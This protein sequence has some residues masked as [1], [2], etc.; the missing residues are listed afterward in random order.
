MDPDLIAAIRALVAM[1]SN[2]RRDM[3]ADH[4]S[5][6][7]PADATAAPRGGKPAPL[8]VDQSPFSTA[9]EESYLRGATNGRFGSADAEK[10]LKTINSGYTTANVLRSMAS[11]P[12]MNYG[13][14]LLGKVPAALGGG[15]GAE[16]DMRL[17]GQLFN[18]KHPVAGAV[19]P[20]AGLAATT[21]ATPEVEGAEA[22]GTG[23]KMLKGAVTGATVGAASSAGASEGPLRDRLR[24]AMYGGAGGAVFGALIPGIA[25]AAGDVSPTAQAMKKIQGAVDESGGPGEVQLQL[26]QHKAAGRG[27]IVTLADLTDPL[28]NTADVAATGSSAARSQIAQLASGRQADQ[29]ERMLNDVRAAVGGDHDAATRIAQLHQSTAAWANGPN[30]YGGIRASDPPIDLGPLKQE[31]RKPELAGAWSLARDADNINKA[32]PVAQLVAK[33]QA[34]V[35]SLSEGEARQFVILSGQ[36]KPRPVSFTD[37]HNM[38]QILD[39]RATSAFNSGKGNLGAAYGKMRDA[40]DQSLSDQVPDYAGV[41]AEY[42]ERKGLERAV[43]AGHDAWG[44]ADAHGLDTQ[45]AALSPDELQEFRH[46]MAGRLIDELGNV[47]TNRDA[48]QRFMTAS[49]TLERK[50]EVTFGDQTTFDNVMTQMNAEK[51]LGKL[52]TTYQGSATAPR[53]ADAIKPSTIMKSAGMAVI[54]HHEYG[55]PGAVGGALYGPLEKVLNAGV[56]HA[57]NTKM[58]SMLMAQGAPAIEDFLEQLRARGAGYGKGTTRVL[59]AAAGQGAGLLEARMRQ[60]LLGD[61]TQTP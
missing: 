22:V 17:R 15:P 25:K 42:A 59:P 9:D 31:F 41:N 14:E 32:D 36:A 50:L 3:Q 52:K 39:D 58:G 28:R 35:P 6:L 37:L 53:L 46:G 12:L 56:V 7:A 45:V 47:A 29:S 20:M 61:S 4:T 40:V 10:Y 19:L 11:G 57:T 24:A 18:D 43:Q 23:M 16:A 8:S 38:K 48:A 49:P 2:A 1:R 60:G 27:N 13:D 5:P 21:L 26:D 55:L 44:K 30:G 51:I 33:L 34:A 54:G